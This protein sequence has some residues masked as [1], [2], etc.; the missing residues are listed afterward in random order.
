MTYAENIKRIERHAQEKERAPFEFNEKPFY[1]AVPMFPYPSGNIHMGHIRNYAIS[2]AIARYKKTKGFN[3]LHPIG[4]D[5]FG[6]PA[7][8]AAIQ[9]G[10]SPKEWTEAN[11]EAMSADFKSM[12]F[13]FDWGNA[14]RTHD[15]SYYRFEQDIFKRAW[16]EGLIYKKEQ[17]VNYDPVDKTILSNEQVHNGKGWRSGAQV[18]RKKMPMYFFNIRRYAQELLDGLDQLSGSWPQRVIEMQRNWI[19]KQSGQSETYRFESGAELAVFIPDAMERPACVAVG[20]NHPFA[21][22]FESDERYQRWLAAASLGGVSQKETF[23]EQHWFD[24]GARLNRGAES[25]GVYIDINRDAESVFTA[26]KSKAEPAASARSGAFEKS[27]PA[28]QIALKDWCVSRQRYWGN[29]IPMI[30]CESCGDIPSQELV[31]LPEDLK[32]DGSGNPL[33]REASFYSCAC[34]SCKGPARRCCDTMDTFVQSAW[35]YQR[36]IDPTAEAMIPREQTQVDVYIGGVEHATMHLIYTR[37]FHKMLRD[38]GMVSTDEPIKKLITQGMVCKKY[39]KPDGSMASAKMSKS[40]GNVVSPQGHID[41]YGA[42]ALQLFIIFAAP[43][44]DNFDFEDSGIVGSYRFLEDVHRY[45]FEGSA[46][47]ASVSSEQAV[48]AVEKMRAHLDREFEGRGNLNTI[49]PQLM[50]AFKA[51]KRC[52]FEDAAEGP[53]RKRAAETRFVEALGIFAPHLAGYIQDFVLSPPGAERK[54]KAAP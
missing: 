31:R 37:F 5:S 29:P 24:T 40:I 52:S 32:P 16:R 36:Y 34:P 53:E 51:I 43:P 23:A 6:M 2:N 42:D 27:E 25:V 9:R 41:K 21:Q 38:F 39:Q 18:V 10:V 17:F 26:E 47:P 49:V 35:Y 7:E 8:A 19:G 48:T 54:N 22:G 4:F 15:E 1:Y 20:V 30:S 46:A 13:D 14:L 33:E 28:T 50:V 3:V 11:I 12:G 44:Q 45:F